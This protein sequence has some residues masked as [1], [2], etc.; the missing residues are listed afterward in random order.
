LVEGTVAVEDELDAS[1]WQE[2]VTKRIRYVILNVPDGDMAAPVLLHG[3][4][5][6]QVAAKKKLPRWRVYRA[7]QDARA[8]I[9]D[10]SELQELWGMRP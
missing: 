1:R 2:R 8:A 4:L 10:D 5:A 6:R 3:I 9:K 7:T